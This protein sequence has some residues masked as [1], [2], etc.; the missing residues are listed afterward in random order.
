MAENKRGH[1][2]DRRLVDA[3]NET[4]PGQLVFETLASGHDGVGLPPSK[5]QMLAAWPKGPAAGC[6]GSRAAL[7]RS[8]P[9]WMAPVLAT[10]H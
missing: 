7:R 5:D 8:L 9:L 4:F 2:S 6:K 3:Q 1:Q 10:E